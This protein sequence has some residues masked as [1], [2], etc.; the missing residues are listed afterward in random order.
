MK[1][2]FQRRRDLVTVLLL[3]IAAHS[4]VILFTATTRENV[5]LKAKA[6]DVGLVENTM[7]VRTK[8]ARCRA[9]T[10]KGGGF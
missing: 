6:C 1:K 3:L 4:V 5:A 9:I 10:V 7:L 8:L 2:S